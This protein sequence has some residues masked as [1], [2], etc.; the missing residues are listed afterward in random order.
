MTI[1]MNMAILFLGWEMDDGLR[2]SLFDTKEA[3]YS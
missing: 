3:N 2:L 1:W